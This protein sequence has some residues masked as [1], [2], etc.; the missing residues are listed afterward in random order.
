MTARYLRD[1]SFV[2]SSF[3]QQKFS[4]ILL[5]FRTGSEMCWIVPLLGV[6][7]RL[8]NMSLPLWCGKQ[9]LLFKLECN[10]CAGCT[11]KILQI[12][13]FHV[14]EIA[15]YFCQM[16]NHPYNS[17]GSVTKQVRLTW[18]KIESNWKHQIILRH[19][20]VF[21]MAVRLCLSPWHYI[22]WVGNRIF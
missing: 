4:I 7:L 18:Q 14:L 5:I 1:C 8:L 6:C 12:L 13:P 15:L 11:R 2:I 20:Y 16:W 22:C 10:I 17:H 3:L 9:S 21:C 19:L